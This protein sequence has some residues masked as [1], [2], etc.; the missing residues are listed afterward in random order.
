M[1]ST[2]YGTYPV[3]DPTEDDKTI[4]VRMETVVAAA[5]ADSDRP[6]TRHAA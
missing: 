5:R 4:D 6:R 1:L 3:P 2:A